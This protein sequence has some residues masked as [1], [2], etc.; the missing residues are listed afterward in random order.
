MSSPRS[1]ADDT[2]GNDG[3]NEAGQLTAKSRGV[4]GMSG[5]R[6][7]EDTSKEIPVSAVV[8][9]GKSVH[10]DGGTRLLL[11]LH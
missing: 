2:S 4:Y 3:L 10:L 1:G 11:I 6:L 5:L 9:N 7:A 8:S